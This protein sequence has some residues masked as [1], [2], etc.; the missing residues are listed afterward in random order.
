[1]LSQSGGLFQRNSS[2]DTYIGLGCFFR[3]LFIFREFVRDWE[4]H[5]ASIVNHINFNKSP[6]PP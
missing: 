1:M 4:C 6:G 5:V 2:T 3:G